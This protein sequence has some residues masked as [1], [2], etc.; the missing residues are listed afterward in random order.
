MRVITV[1]VLL[2]GT[3]FVLQK[4]ISYGEFLAFILLTNVFL[5]PIQKINTIIE[6]YPKGIAGFKRY[7]EILETEPDVADESGA[8]EAGTLRGDIHSYTLNSLRRQIGIVQQDVFLFSGTIRENLAYGRLEATEEKILRPPA[9]QRLA[10]ARMFLK[11]PPI[12]ILDEATSALDTEMEAAIQQISSGAVAGAHHPGDCSPSGHHPRRG[13]DCGGDGGGHRRYGH[14]EE[15]LPL[16][17]FSFLHLHSRHY[18][19]LSSVRHK[20]QLSDIFA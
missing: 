1:F 13:P 4:E 15:L 12:L 6:S 20:R 11:N 19:G 16:V 3:W 17:V 2:C 18:S 7:M 10:I 9:A 14:H 8:A 5:G